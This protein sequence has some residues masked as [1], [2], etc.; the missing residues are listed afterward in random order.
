MVRQ[1]GLPSLRMARELSLLPLNENR[2]GLLNRYFEIDE[3][4]L[5][6]QRRSLLTVGEQE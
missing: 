4:R 5:E 2:N 1:P 3:K 6:D